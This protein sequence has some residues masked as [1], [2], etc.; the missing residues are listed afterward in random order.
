[1]SDPRSAHA[2]AERLELQTAIIETDAAL[3]I[4]FSGHGDVLH[5]AAAM[6]S[7]AVDFLVKPIEEHILIDAINRG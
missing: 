1:M 4:V 7:G 6:K 5:T 2:G 3:S